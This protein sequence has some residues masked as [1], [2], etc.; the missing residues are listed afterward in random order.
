V[1]TSFSTGNVY[2][3][4][5]RNHVVGIMTVDSKSKLRQIRVA[6]NQTG[7][8]LFERKVSDTIGRLYR[9]VPSNNGPKRALASETMVNVNRSFRT[10][11]GGMPNPTYGPLL[12][13]LVVSSFSL[14]T[15]RGS[16]QILFH[17]RERTQA[18]N[19]EITRMSGELKARFPRLRATPRP[20]QTRL[21]CRPVFR[22]YSGVAID[23]ESEDK[24]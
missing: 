1:V 2:T 7:R 3:K 5:F 15:A 10:P 16:R 13:R 11:R 4:N 6:R 20:V 18:L 9:R 8:R 22:D 14:T 24:E 12:K 23:L 19:P 17:P 21:E